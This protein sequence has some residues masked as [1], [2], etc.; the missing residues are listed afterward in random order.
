MDKNEQRAFFEKMKEKY[1]NDNLKAVFKGLDE[2]DDPNAY[3]NDIVKKALEDAEAIAKA[4]KESIDSKNKEQEK[5]PKQSDDYYT[6]YKTAIGIG[7]RSNSAD[8]M[9]LESIKNNAVSHILNSL[10]IIVKDQNDKIDK[11]FF[12]NFLIAAN[13]L[14]STVREI[15]RAEKNN[16]ILKDRLNEL[17]SDK[18]K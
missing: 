18:D 5:Q 6:G 17:K 15:K 9:F 16:K 14:I 13:E 4:V 1:S 10:E 11:E 3:F 8:I 7:V 12:S 2:A